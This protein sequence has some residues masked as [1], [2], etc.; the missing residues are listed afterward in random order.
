VAFAV[1]AGIPV[2]AFSPLGNADAVGST[3]GAAPEPAGVAAGVAAPESAWDDDEPP[4]PPQAVSA[5]A[6][7]SVNAAQDARREKRADAAGKIVG[8]EVVTSGDFA[9]DLVA[10]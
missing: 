4:P 9:V 6:K 5:S 3:N 8:F 7:L 2:S 10:P 1:I